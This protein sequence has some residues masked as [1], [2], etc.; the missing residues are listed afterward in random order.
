MRGGFGHVYVSNNGKLVVDRHESDEK[1]LLAKQ[2]NDTQPLYSCR[3]YV[4]NVIPKEW[5]GKFGLF[6]V[7]KTIDKNGNT[8]AVNM[9]FT[10]VELTPL[11]DESETLEHVLDRALQTDHL[12]K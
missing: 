7:S 8:T 10:P 1:H 9:M 4:E 2:T 11:P 12:S 6:T 5:I 3:A